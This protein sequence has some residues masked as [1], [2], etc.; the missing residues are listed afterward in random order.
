MFIG[1]KKIEGTFE[2]E[3]DK[4]KV[5]FDDSSSVEINKKLLELIQHKEKGEGG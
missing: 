5:E 1:S 2:L 3:N 4:V